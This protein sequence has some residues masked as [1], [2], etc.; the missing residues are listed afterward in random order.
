MHESALDKLRTF[1]R[2]Y[3][4]P[5][6]G[7][8][9]SILDVGSAVAHPGH[10]S[11]R[12]VM[13]NPAWKLQGLDIEAGVNVD[14]VVQEPYDWREVPSGS[15]DIVTCS[16][17]FEHAEYFWI[18]MMEIS[19]V[20][21]VHGLAFINAPGSGPLH[22]Y[23]V[24]CWRFYDD[25]FPALARYSGLKLL[26]AQVQWAPAYRKGL[27]WRDAT[28]IMQR[29]MRTADEEQAA[30]WRVAGAKLSARTA[31]TPE[32]LMGV[33]APAPSAQASE[34]GRLEG[35]GALAERADAL[36]GKT[37]FGHRLFLIR[38]ELRSIGQIVFRP[39][40]DLRL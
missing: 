18:T 13:D 24:D 40:R 12:Q 37:G 27:Q 20:L 10:D 22:R 6:E 32:T 4:A 19:R 38:R 34:I 1:R 7:V 2:C 21:K 31:I 14:I 11:N 39:L 9:L 3:L 16:Q 28:A 15:V 26:E 29:P 25:A 5:Y 36:L 33:A 23:P 35:K 8:P 30:A 17:V